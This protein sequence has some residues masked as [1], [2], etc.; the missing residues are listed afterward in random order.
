[1]SDPTRAVYDCMIFLQAASRP[2]RVHGTFRLVREGAVKLI[3]SAQIVNEVRDVLTRPEVRA[4]FPA[5]TPEHVGAFLNDILSVA[6]T[7]DDV[8]AVFTLPRDPKDEP[9]VNLA[10]RAQASYLVTWNDRHLTYL[11]R[12]DTAE[13]REFSNRFPNIK[14][15]DPPTFVREIEQIRHAPTDVPPAP[16]QPRPGQC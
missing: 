11:M 1:M 8:P 3:V 13:G 5:L 9:Y 4:K 2:D 15:V 16:D 14:I 12:Q 7:V 10:I 6:L